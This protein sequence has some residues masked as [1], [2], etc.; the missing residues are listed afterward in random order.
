MPANS[1]LIS[2]NWRDVRVSAL[3][4]YN[5]GE[6]PPCSRPVAPVTCALGSP[7][8]L[9][10]DIGSDLLRWLVLADTPYWL[11]LHVSEAAIIAA[12]RAKKRLVRRLTDHPSLLLAAGEAGEAGE[13]GKAGVLPLPHLAIAKVRSKKHPL[14]RDWLPLLDRLLPDMMAH[15]RATDL[16]DRALLTENNT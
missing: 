16:K 15:L 1:P 7:R 3:R 10:A 6:T 8:E 4:A 2:E 11:P 12:W 5:A 13:A 14:C 9:Q